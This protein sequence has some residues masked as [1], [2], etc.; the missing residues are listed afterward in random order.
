VGKCTSGLL[1]WSTRLPVVVFA[2]ID[3]HVTACVSTVAKL[4]EVQ[5]QHFIQSEVNYKYIFSKHKNI[6]KTHV[7]FC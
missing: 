6:L 2:V 7:E 5:I 3:P 4:L 1:H